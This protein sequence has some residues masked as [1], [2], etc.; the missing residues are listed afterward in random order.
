[1][2]RRFISAL[3][4]AIMIGA[5]TAIAVLAITVIYYGVGGR[6]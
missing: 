5:L 4:S 1:M 2:S 3:T 6:G